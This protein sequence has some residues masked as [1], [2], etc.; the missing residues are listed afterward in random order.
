MPIL[1]PSLSHVSLPHYSP[2]QQL[3][4][5]TMKPISLP[6]AP[7]TLEPTVAQSQDGLAPIEHSFPTPKLSHGEPTVHP[8]ARPGL[9]V[10]SHNH[11][12]HY[13]CDL[14]T[15]SR[16]VGYA[17]PTPSNVGHHHGIQS[18]DETPNTT[19]KKRSRTWGYTSTS[20][21]APHV[22]AR[23]LP[24]LT[25]LA[26]LYM[27]RA[28]A[29]RVVFAFHWAWLTYL[30]LT[31]ANSALA[32]IFVGLL[33]I[34]QP[35][36]WPPLHGN[37]FQAYTIQRLWDVFWHQ[38]GALSQLHNGRHYPQ[39]VEARTRKHCGKDDSCSLGICRVGDYLCTCDLEDQAGSR[40]G[41]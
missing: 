21:K 12:T 37:P 11:H 8:T 6:D 14:G 7:S 35:D 39:G 13:T 24:L 30:I 36:E 33:Q 34:A 3:L 1:A 32:I 31:A 23:R 4:S 20:P 9:A 17:S 22:V 41:P 16:V 10:G 40:S 38:I 19:P 28:A 25:V 18:P 29:F 27:D 15:T 26:A 2:K 5:P